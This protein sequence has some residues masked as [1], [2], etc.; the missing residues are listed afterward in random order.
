MKD[1]AKRI[2]QEGKTL[3]LVGYTDKTV[4]S[5]D[6]PR[7]TDVANVNAITVIN[8]IPGPIVRMV[9]NEGRELENGN[10]MASEMALNDNSCN[11]PTIT[12]WRVEIYPSL[13]SLTI[14]RNCLRNLKEFA[15]CN[16]SML[17]LVEV[18]AGSLASC[19]EL[20]ITDCSLLESIDLKDNSFA[21]CQEVCL[22]SGTF[23][24][25]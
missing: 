25:G 23:S 15:L 4:N 9:I 16:L 12:S 8:P 6:V 2:Q 5:P 11:E 3:L 10:A 22:Q 1:A 7:P 14:G 20:R 21:T 24:D 17:K 13:Q 19:A 18:G